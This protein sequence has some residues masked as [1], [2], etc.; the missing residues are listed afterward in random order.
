MKH[1]FES[2]NNSTTRDYLRIDLSATYHFNISEGTHLD[3]GASVWNLLNTKN[4]I[5]TYYYLNENNQTVKV[6]NL[7]LGLTPNVF[8]RITL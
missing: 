7:S 6:E 2:P 5:N 1:P 8:A 3:L 4:I